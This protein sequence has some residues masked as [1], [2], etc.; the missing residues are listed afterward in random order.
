[1][2]NGCGRPSV[3][4]IRKFCVECMG[5]DRQ[6]VKECGSRGCTLHRFRFGS[7][8]NFGEALRQ[9]RRERAFVQCFGK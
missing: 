3:K 7:N 5:G 4:L 1:M 2:G 6:L 8:P 9:E